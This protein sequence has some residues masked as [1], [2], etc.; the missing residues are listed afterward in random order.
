M[1]SFERERAQDGFIQREIDGHIIRFRVSV[2]PMVGTELKNKFESV[3]I[4]ILDDR[5]VIKDLDKLGLTGMQ[6]MF[7]KSNKSAAGNGYSYRT[8]RKR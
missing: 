3:V 2:L 8:Y 1:D 5:K 6:K 4:R 7:Y